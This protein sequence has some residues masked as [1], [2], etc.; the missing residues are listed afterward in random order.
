MLIP[1]LLIHFYCK[2]E[3]MSNDVILNFV[4]IIEN[5]DEIAGLVMSFKFGMAMR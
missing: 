3:M 5:K 2:L 4:V 1:Y